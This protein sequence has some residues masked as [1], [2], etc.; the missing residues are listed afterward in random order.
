VFLGTVGRN[1]GASA[2]FS[3]LM[4]S[5]GESRQQLVTTTRHNHSITTSDEVTGYTGDSLNDTEVL[6]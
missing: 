2:R 4:I 5:A 1:G 6:N 3:R